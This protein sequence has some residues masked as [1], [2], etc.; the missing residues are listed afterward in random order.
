MTICIKEEQS[1][2][3]M[4][5]SIKG[6]DDVNEVSLVGRITKDPLLRQLPSGKVQ[7]SFILAVNR[8]YKNQEGS[9]DTD[10]ILCTIWGRLAE[11]TVR[12]CGKGSLIGVAGRIQSRSYERSDKSRAYVTEIIG[13][14]VHFIAT[15][16]RATAEHYVQQMSTDSAAVVSE[17][18]ATTH[19]HLPKGEKELPIL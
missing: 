5:H 13:E 11:N 7:S 6:G 10:F 12:F 9:V 15:K 8:N 1:I 2:M 16:E 18:T 4:P 14:K 19:F 17:E 3:I